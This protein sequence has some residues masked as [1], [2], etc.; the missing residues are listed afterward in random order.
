MSQTDTGFSPE[1][2]TTLRQHG[3]VLFAG[4]V[5][6]EAQPSMSARRL[7]ERIERLQGFELP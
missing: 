7:S 2:I 1:E 5:I 3:V 6:F 4:R